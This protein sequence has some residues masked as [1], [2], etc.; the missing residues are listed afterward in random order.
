MVSGI[1]RRARVAYTKVLHGK[2]KQRRKWL[3]SM[4]DHGRRR[5]LWV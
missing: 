1:I 3:E 5:R 4:L 2:E